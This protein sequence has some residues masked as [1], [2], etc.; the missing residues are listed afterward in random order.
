MIKHSDNRATA[1]LELLLT[2]PH[3]KKEIIKGEFLFQEGDEAKFIYYLISG[4]V[5]IGKFS[6]DGREITY[7]ICGAHDF[8]GEFTLFSPLSHY[9]V[10]AKVIE[11]G[12][13]A[14]I[15]H[16]DLEENL[17]LKPELNVAYIRRMGIHQRIN[18]SKIRD[19]VLNGKKGALYSTLIRMAN[20]YGIPQEN[21]IL[22]NRVF[23]N[24]EFA[25]FCGMSREVV[26]RML[27]KLKQQQKLSVIQ[28]K[29]LIHDVQYLKNEIH[30]EN[31][32][33]EICNID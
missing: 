17:L 21:G 30:C 31:C 10:H 6:L 12:V 1:D 29:I 4:K 23:T 32:P 11:E 33:I 9:K 13:C 2:I 18:E 28:G 20:S 25:N 24:Q 15:H 19:L 7:R 8:I 16:K 27:G 22:I 5:R 26:N 3:S 14:K